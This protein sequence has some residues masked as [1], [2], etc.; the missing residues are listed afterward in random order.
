CCFPAAGGRFFW[1]TA[2]CCRGGC[3]HVH[4]LYPEVASSVRTSGGCLWQTA[5]MRPG[6]ASHVHLGGWRRLALAARPGPILRRR[7]AFKGRPR[8]GSRPPPLP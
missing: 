6:S 5:K 8:F 3:R 7:R 1:P 4:G 2:G